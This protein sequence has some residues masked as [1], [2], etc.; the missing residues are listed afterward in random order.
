MYDACS[1]FNTY[2]KD[3]F[4]IDINKNLSQGDTLHQQ[5]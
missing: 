4:S 3:T 5:Y 1:I 2:R